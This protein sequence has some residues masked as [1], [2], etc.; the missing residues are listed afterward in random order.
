MVCTQAIFPALGV[1][2]TSLKPG[3]NP[4]NWNSLNIPLYVDR[5]NKALEEFRSL[6]QRVGKCVHTIEAAV[7]D[8]ESANLVRES[9]FPIGSA[10]DVADFFY[11]VGSPACPIVSV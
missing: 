4:L 10:L 7:A 2:Q 8:I 11:K 9:D 3:F 1:L 6:V 5:S